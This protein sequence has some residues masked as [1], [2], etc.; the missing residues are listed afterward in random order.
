MMKKIVTSLALVLCAVM[1]FACQS[2][3]TTSTDWLEGKW[4]SKEWD[5]T[6][7]IDEKDGTWSIVFDEGIVVENAELSVEG[8][9]FTLTDKE[10]THYV[11]EQQ[12]DTKILYQKV[13]DEGVAGTTDQVTF[14]KV[15]E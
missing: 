11:M 1:L 4:Y 3:Q 8:K 5:M 10:G 6:Y 14:E 13:G 2:K 15:E 9:V 7:E 12:S